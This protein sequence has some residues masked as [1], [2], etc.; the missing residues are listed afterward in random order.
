MKEKINR[1]IK[2]R[3][4]SIVFILVILVV[5]T[6][7]VYYPNQQQLLSSFAFL[8]NQQGLHLEELS[9]GI[10]LAEAYPITDEVGNQSDPYKFKIVNNSNKE[11]KYQIIF[12][13]QLDKIEARG[14]EALPAK[15]LRYSLQTEDSQLTE[16][17]PDDE[18]IYET[19]I[20][21]NSEV[22]FNFRLWL[23]T[24][25]DADGMGKTF[26]GQM[27]IKEI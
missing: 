25:L 22:V 2:S 1:Q 5:G 13:N 8:Q 19:V 7:Y 4:M 14:F 17:L 26:I 3:I 16:T 24:N 12:K 10:K 6:I 11:V 15:Y 20:N 23:G 21:A 9:S 27:E 18:I